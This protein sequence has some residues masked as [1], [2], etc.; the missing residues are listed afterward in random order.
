MKYG[1]VIEENVSKKLVYLRNNHSAEEP[2]I[3]T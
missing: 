3:V 1:E 2:E